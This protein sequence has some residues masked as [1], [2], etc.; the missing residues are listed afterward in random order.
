MFERA[1]IVAI[2]SQE[3]QYEALPKG[4]GLV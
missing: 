3:N 2:E 1:L 4:R